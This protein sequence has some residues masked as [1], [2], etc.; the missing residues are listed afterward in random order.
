MKSIKLFILAFCL[1]LASSCSLDQLVDPNNVKLSG[2][3]PTLVLS[4]IQS[5][6]AGLFQATS[7][8]GMQ[9][10]RLLN[11]GGVNYS[12][13]FQ[14]QSFD[15]IW[16]LA[17]AGILQDAD[18]VIKYAD[19]NGWS[20]HGGMARVLT[21]FTLLQLVDLFGDVPYK[22][23][24][25][26]LD[27]LNAKVDPGAD[28]YASVLAMLD[29]AEL[30]FKT[31]ATTAVPAGKLNPLAETPVDF[32]Y[33]N[34][35]T[36]WIRLINSLKLKTYLNQGGKK[37]EIDAVIADADGL[38]TAQAHNFVFRYG[39]NLSDP[40]SRH[41]NFIGQYPAGG[42]AYM[43]NH[44][45]WQ[46]FHA[47]NATNLVGSTTKSANPGDPRM[48]F[49]FYRQ[50]NANNT[51]PNNIRC[52]TASSIPAHFPSKVGSAIVYGVAGVPPGISTDPNNPAWLGAVGTLSRTF[53][54][55]TDRGYWGRDHVNNEG[56]PPD[57]L[58][59]T[60]WGAYPSGGRF[61]GSSQQGVNATTR[62]GMFGAGIQ[63][64]MMR[65]FV[66]F[67]LAEAALKL[68]T[69][70]TAKTYYSTGINYS[71]TDVRDW[72]VNGTYGIGSAVAT[73]AIAGSNGSTGI[74]TFYTAT[75]YAADVANYVTAA[76]AAYDAAL[77]ISSNDAL[78]YVARE[79]WVAAFGNGM[80]AYNLYRRT[81]MPTGMQP[82]IQPN[83]GAFPRSVWYPNTFATLNNTVKQ[84]TN[85]TGR[86]FWDTNVSNLDF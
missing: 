41:P 55:P 10:T 58:L 79:F 20:R 42:G 62:G 6:T 8:V 36:S 32:Y 18:N 66:Q 19:Q 1:L 45:I 22:E 34:T 7:S 33:A 56:I 82:T 28:I 44:L 65:S 52:V 50:V 51:D 53:C 30:D 11:P 61:D 83:P 43:S 12:N 31:N 37:A 9:V 73:E 84:K 81:G 13:V 2:L 80:E 38:I 72:A 46:M 49:Y 4:S 23:T 71:F 60:A 75:D 76:N 59:R 63:P 40:D 14:P 5:S 77:I 68:S 25:K 74:N 64:M 85:L 78:N 27:N 24:L 57:N 70:G 48:R 29:Q 67:M 26:G 35:Y 17:Y 15:G 3:R 39:T 16:S 54:Y 47:Y 69:T 86:I 21:A